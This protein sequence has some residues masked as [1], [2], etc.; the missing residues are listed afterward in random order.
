M[1]SI[2]GRTRSNITLVFGVRQGVGVIAP[3]VIYGAMTS[4]LFAAYVTDT[5]GPCLHPGDVV[6]TDR[7]NA[8]KA[9]GAANAIAARGAQLQLLPPY[10]PDLTPIEN[11][12]SKVKT[13]LR[14]AA[15]RTWDA[16]VDAAA[17]ALHAVTPEDVY[18]W[19]KHAGFC[20]KLE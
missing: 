10:S 16:L 3:N 6:V 9:T 15:A 17:D 13:A 7:L 12:G 19:L 11:A 4:E 5:L 1:G 20:P 2:P 14:K 8:H 18:G